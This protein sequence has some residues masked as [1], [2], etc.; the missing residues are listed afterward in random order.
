MLVTT[1]PL[2]QCTFSLLL[3][4]FLYISLV[5]EHVFQITNRIYYQEAKPL[6]YK[7]QLPLSYS[8]HSK[9]TPYHYNIK[10]SHIGFWS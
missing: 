4:V 2:Q 5:F 10:I 3:G 1:I 8:I 9:C 7:N 6:P